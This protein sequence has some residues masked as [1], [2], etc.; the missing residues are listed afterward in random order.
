MKKIIAIYI[1]SVI[2]C[3]LQAQERILTLKQC[4]DTAIANNMTI[5][6][7]GLQ[8]NTDDITRKQARLD[9]FPDLT[10]FA[11]QGI[12]QG[13]SIDPFTNTYSNQQISFSNYGL[14]TGV[15][16][17]NGFSAQNL[18]RQTALSFEASKMDWQ[19]AKDNITISVILSYLTVLT[20]EELLEQARVQAGLTKK[21]VERLDLLNREGAISP[22][23]LYD[24]KGQY[25]TDE[26][27]II[28]LQHDLETAKITLTQIMNVPYDKKISVE[29]L[30]VNAIASVYGNNADGVY[31][32]ALQNFSLVKAVD[33]RARSADAVKVAKGRL[34]PELRLNGAVNT[35][36]SSVATQ[37]TFLNSTNITST[38]YV[39]V[40]GSP[41]PVIK[42][43]NNY[44]IQKINY[45][46]QLSNNLYSSIR[47]NLTIPIFNNGRRRNAVKLSQ[48]ILDNAKREQ[49]STKTQLQQLVEQAYT[50]MIATLHRQRTLTEQVEAYAESFRAAE[51]RFN[52]GVGTSIDYLTAKN[53]LDRAK[54]NL[55]A[56]KYDYVLRTKVLDYYAGK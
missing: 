48:L 22:P 42:Q 41:S 20:N 52:N 14:S 8:M 46:D 17:F 23:T 11:S 33:L 24:L 40:N 26:I 15:L 34:F 32:S 30:D 47:L 44:S 54:S 55:I 19:Q 36:Y 53:N 27:N 3:E 25:N 37:S 18:V 5:Q 21:Q 31:Q 1:L 7:A 13:R 9:R 6:R 56:A 39:L 51:V 29:K 38:D 35:N 4:I 10:G 45:A 49:Q 16:L 12:N 50:D 2:A 28:N 43:Q